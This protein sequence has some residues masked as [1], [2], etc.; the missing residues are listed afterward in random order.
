MER[1]IAA[2]LLRDL[3]C[4]IVRRDAP[5]GESLEGPL[6]VIVDRGPSSGEL[7]RPA[8]ATL[9]VVDER[10][11]RLGLR[12]GLRVTEATAL[13][14][15]L[16]VRHVAE[17]AITAALGAVAEVALTLGGVASICPLDTVWLDI[18]GAAH[19]VG[20]ELALKQE[21]QSR[22]AELG[23]RCRVAIADGPRLARA[24]AEWGEEPCIAE[25]GRGAEA[26]APLPL[27]ALSLSVETLSLFLRLGVIT[28]GDLARLPRAGVSAR[29]PSGA[30]SVLSL[31]LGHDPMPLA[32]YRPPELLEERASFEEGVGEIEALL[33]V[34]RGM[35]SRLSSRLVARGVSAARVE[36]EIDYDRSIVRLQSSERALHL[37]AS[38]ATLVLLVE[39]PMPL[40]RAE[41]LFRAVRAKLEAFGSTQGL[42]A[43]AVGLTLRLSQL[44]PQRRVQLDLSRDRAADPDALLAL[45]AELSAEVGPARVGTLAIEDAHRPEKRSRLCPVAMGQGRAPRARAEPRVARVAEPRVVRVAEPSRLLPEPLPLG[46]VSLRMLASEQRA[47][48]V[49]HHL[50]QVGSVELSHRLSGV[51][52]W[53]GA[54]VS[55]DYVRASLT[56]QGEHPAIGEAWIYWDRA[57]GEA[58]LHGW[59]E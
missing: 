30:A 4:E 54:P 37:G 12:P 29:L 47:L 10:A 41:D 50:Y 27:S 2:I 6:G 13:I 49:G 25:P 42:R 15:K 7:E 23:H 34:L 45:L 43:P 48:A 26:I 1:R 53:T 22:V 59:W 44:A 5:A 56:S 46:R 57:V 39:L 14:S 3:P 40:S 9:D 36:V 31:V 18:T 32:P 19:L 21:L 17:D 16:T 8:E 24:L 33:F 52:W 11:R 58:F 51:E 35:T 55:R 20:G 28:V 38:E